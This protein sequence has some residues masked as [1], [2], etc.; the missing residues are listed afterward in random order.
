MISQVIDQEVCI[1]ASI[2]TV[3]DAL[4]NPDVTEKYWGGTR[5]ESEWKK[6]STI[7]YRRDGE[8]MDE[9]KLLEIVSHRF[10]EHTFKPMF[11]EFKEEP[12]SLVS[13]ILT[14]EGPATR[15]AVL[16]RNFP[17]SSKVFTACRGGWP[18]IL[19]SLKTLLESE[20][21]A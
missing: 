8:I 4:T 19:K 7:Y 12:P 20:D 17:P 15:I 11:G 21:Y 9:H 5:I 1:S 2:S 6:G 16:H 13:I 3:W 18:E 10:I 14:E